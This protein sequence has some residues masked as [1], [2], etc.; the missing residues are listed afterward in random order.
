MDD[1]GRC[2]LVL[3]SG[4]ANDWSHVKTDEAQI[5]PDRLGVGLSF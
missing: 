4:E 5:S 3:V 1:A 2:I